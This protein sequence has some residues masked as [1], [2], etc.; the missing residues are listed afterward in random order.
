MI[1]KQCDKCDKIIEGYTK[2]QVD[3]MMEQHKLAK[4]KEKQN[5]K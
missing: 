4:H 5:A 2:N 3:Y 1:K